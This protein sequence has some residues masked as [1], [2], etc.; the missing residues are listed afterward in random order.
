MTIS[1][2]LASSAH[3]AQAVHWDQE[4]HDLLAT[5]S[6]VQRDLLAVLSEKQ[7]RLAQPDLG[8]LDEIQQREAELIVRLE[9]VQERRRLLL[10]RAAHDGLPADNLRALTASLPADQRQSLTP[11]IDRAGARASLLQHQGLANWVVV[12]R[13]LLHLSH[14]LEIIATGGR[15]QPTYGKENTAAVS[16]GLV[17]QAA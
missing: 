5:L 1:T 7:R 11:Q 16:G 13:T 8:A 10:E 3:D 12:Q 6:E 17:D 2:Q 9:A 15:Q 14:L 4:L